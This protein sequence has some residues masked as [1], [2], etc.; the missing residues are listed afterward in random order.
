MKNKQRGYALI[1]VLIISALLLSLAGLF[2]KMVYNS[3]AGGNSV[4]G[5]AQAFYLAEAGIEKGKAELTSNSNWY[6]DLSHS[7]EDDADWLINTAT[8]Q[9]NN[10]GEGTFKIIREQGKMLLYSV[11]KRGKGICIQKITFDLFPLKEKQWE[12]I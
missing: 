4:Y 6:T 11:G 5:R 9:T 2:A 3:M 10:L 1:L 8:G 12:I 7:P